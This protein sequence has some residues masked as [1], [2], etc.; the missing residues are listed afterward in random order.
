MKPLNLVRAMLR[1]FGYDL[2]RRHDPYADE[3]RLLDGQAG[4]IFDVGANVGDVTAEFR[5]HFP[6]AAVH[7]FEPFA[8]PFGTLTR[9]FQGDPAVRTVQCAVADRSGA[10]TFHLNRKDTTNSLLPNAAAAQEW[11]SPGKIGAVGSVQV[12][13]VTLEQYCREQS[14]EQIDLLKI[15]VQGGEMMVLRGAEALLARSAVSLIYA[16]ALFVP[17]YEGQAWF[18]ELAAHL[19]ARGYALFNLYEMKHGRGLPQLLWANALFVSEAVRSAAMKAAQ[20]VR[21]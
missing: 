8:E 14:I 6:R 15:D 19:A 2:R 3:R 7:C 16:E 12:P 20:M 21:P 9:R 18:H 13:V 11:V 1:P 5:R 4:T 17:L 10:A